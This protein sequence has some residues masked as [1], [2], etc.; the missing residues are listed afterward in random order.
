MRAIIGECTLL[1]LAQQKQVFL[2]YQTLFDHQYIGEILNQPPV[3]LL[4]DKTIIQIKILPNTLPISGQ[5]FQV[6]PN[7]E[8]IREME[9]L[10]M[11][12]LFILDL[13]RSM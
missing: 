11:V 2:I 7:S 5:K 10:Q 3:H 8:A 6:S 13:N 9:A 12:H 4:S 1:L